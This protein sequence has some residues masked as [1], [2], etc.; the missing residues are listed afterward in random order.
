VLRLGLASVTALPG[1]V[2]AREII[3]NAVVA[4]ARTVCPAEGRD[5]LNARL[6]RFAK[7]IIQ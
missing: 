2:A 6:N 7:A 1:Q 4:D 5:A 3:R